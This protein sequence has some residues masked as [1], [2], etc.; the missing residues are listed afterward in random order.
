M[1]QFSYITNF[2]D[3]HGTIFTS[4]LHTNAPPGKD[5]QCCPDKL[6][7]CYAKKGLTV[8][9]NRRVCSLEVETERRKTGPIASMRRYSLRAGVALLVVLNVGGIGMGYIQYEKQRPM[10][11]HLAIGTALNASTAALDND[12]IKVGVNDRLTRVDEGITALVKLS[13]EGE[14]KADRIESSVRSIQ[15][16]THAAV[17][18]PYER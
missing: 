13:R 2:E 16:S 4:H 17:P 7:S 12:A 10:I 18:S 11:E 1:Q 5:G 3:E 8:L 9:S 15:R 14:I 6:A